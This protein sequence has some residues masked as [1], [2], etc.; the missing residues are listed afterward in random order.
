MPFCQY[1]QCCKQLP[2]GTLHY[3]QYTVDCHR[4]RA[5]HHIQKTAALTEKAIQLN[6]DIQQYN[7]N[8]AVSNSTHLPTT[9]D[10]F[11]S[12]P[13]DSAE[14]KPSYFIDDLFINDSVN[15]LTDIS[16]IVE[17]LL[18]IKHKHRLEITVMNCFCALL[19]QE[20][21]GNCPATWNEVEKQI[22]DVKPQHAL[23]TY[24][25]LI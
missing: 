12:P 15:T 13:N 1:G 4:Q 16:P 21:V 20:N 14:T 19:H 9:S 24:T 10:V 8:G 22:E 5:E 2:Y 11:I 25:Y 3:H 23:V 7:L 17:V 6:N 18:Q